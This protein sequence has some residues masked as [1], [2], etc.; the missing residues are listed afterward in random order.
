M[1]KGLQ[2]ELQ[3]VEVSEVMVN[4]VPVSEVVTITEEEIEEVSVRRV[5]RSVQEEEN[6]EQ[7]AT[8]SEQVAV[9]NEQRA[10]SSE[11]Q[12]VSSEKEASKSQKISIEEKTEHKQNLTDNVTQNKQNPTF[13]S[14]NE[15]PQSSNDTTNDATPLNAKRSTLNAHKFKELVSKIYDRDYDLGS[16]FERNITFVSFEDDLLT[17]ESTAEEDDKKML[18]K[19]WGIINMFVK[20][21]FGFET[22]IKNIAK[23]KAKTGSSEQVEGSSEGTTSKPDTGTSKGTP[24]PHTDADAGSMIE[25]VEMKSS[26]IAPE[27]GDTE[28]AKE[29]DPSTLLEEPMVKT[30]LELFSPKKVRIK[31]K[32]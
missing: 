14:Q 3:G 19:H 5:A 20:E 18:I 1:I 21:I 11:Q 12:E 28:A 9:S 15:T 23:K 13:S 25:E 10:V 4:S 31:R 2:K 24:P 26:C 30:A 7:R 22:K 29:K 27:A 8:I 32:T 16:C 6:K 17:W